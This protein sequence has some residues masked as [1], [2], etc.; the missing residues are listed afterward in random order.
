MDKRKN[1][2]LKLAREKALDMVIAVA[3]LIVIAL[4]LITLTIIFALDVVM[5]GT[6][7]A[8]SNWGALV[9][10]VFAHFIGVYLITVFATLWG[11]E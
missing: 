10:W 4:V 9:L 8:Q 6:I 3:L 2:K 1:D 5:F 11:E 7:L